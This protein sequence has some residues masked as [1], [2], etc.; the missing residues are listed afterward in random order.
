MSLKWDK[1]KNFEGIMVLDPTWLTG[2]HAG[3]LEH[4]AR[5]PASQEEQVGKR[6]EA[7]NP[8]GCV[9]VCALH[10][11]NAHPRPKSGILKLIWSTEQ[12]RRQKAFGSFASL[13]LSGT[14]QFSPHQS[15][16]WCVLCSEA[17]GETHISFELNRSHEISIDVFYFWTSD[18]NQTWILNLM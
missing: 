15:A 1:R 3:F 13:G 6:A 17:K 18:L 5:R 2:L 12:F 8:G 4:L 9:P 14:K 10:Q 11:K 16:Q 7:R